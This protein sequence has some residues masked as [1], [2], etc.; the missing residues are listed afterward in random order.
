MTLWLAGCMLAFVLAPDITPTWITGTQDWVP[1]PAVSQAAERWRDASHAAGV[2]RWTEALASYRDAVY[3]SFPRAGASPGF[4]DPGPRPSMPPMGAPGDSIPGMVASA[5]PVPPASAPAPMDPVAPS[6]GPSAAD[7]SEAPAHAGQH[8]ASP[9]VEPAGAEPV[10]QAAR[11]QRV[12]IVGA[13]SIQFELGRELENAWSSCPGVQVRRDG[14]H[15]TGLARIDYFNWLE[16]AAQLVQDFRP[17]LVIAQVGGNDCQGMTHPNGRTA[18]RWD[19]EQ[20]ETLY[21]ERVAEFVRIFR[22]AGAE[23]VVVGMPIMRSPTYRRKMERLNRVTRQAVEGMGQWY[24]STWEM[25][26]TPA[27]EYTEHWTI[28]GRNRVFRASDGT[29]LSN[30]GAIYVTRELM[31]IVSERW[32]TCR[33]P[34]GDEG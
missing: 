31:R 30:W 15:S 26:A 27:G 10:A 19:E 29:H 7:P 28:D 8:E 22:D 3:D 34:G 12:L 9:G 11:F 18:A 24:I 14:R 1:S 13:S 17:D 6:E 2:G 4:G 23:V 16:R 21:G 33:P 25:T 20:W 5:P 32:G